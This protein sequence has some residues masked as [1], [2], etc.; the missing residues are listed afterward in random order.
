[1]RTL[2]WFRS[3][4]RVH[5]H[6]ALFH[7]C[8]DSDRGVVG[9][10][11]LSPGEWRAHDTAAV[12]IDFTLRT[13]RELSRDLQRL[14]VPL[15]IARSETPGEIPRTLLAIAKR[16]AC[17]GIAF[18][19]EYE[20]D[21]RAR[22]AEVARAFERARL[23]ACAYDDQLILEPGSVRTKADTWF[24][25]FTP[26]KNQWMNVLESREFA[27]PLAAPKKRGE[28]VCPPDEVPNAIEGF[29]SSVPSGLWPA[30][31]KHARK[32]L[33][34]F[35]EQRL[36][37][38]KSDRDAPAIDG[39]STLSPYLA[40][41]AVSPRQCL[42]AAM[43][44]NNAKASGGRPGPDHWISELVWREFYHHLLVAF[45]RLCKHRPFK[46]ATERI[47]WSRDEALFARWCDGNTGVPIVD[48]A[49]R[50]LVQTGWM[51]NRCRMIVAMYLT[52][53][54]WIDWRWGER[55]FMRHLVD[56]NLACNN[57]GW[58]WSASTGTDA[59]PY[60][61]IYNPVSQSVAHDPDGAYIKRFVPELRGLDGES[62]HDPG[63]LPP[64]A[65]AKLDYPEVAV[66]HAKARERVMREFRGIA[67]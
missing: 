36:D 54:Y 50:Q 61:R 14:G 64:L 26:F 18:N 35:I 65:R 28:L 59:A 29:E 57:G 10:Y 4:L 15:L 45:P 11:N 16:H 21:E 66:D 30:G 3:D 8:R 23:A 41:G 46:L 47:E 58:Q 40:I 51:H 2:V 13:L 5:D 67:N 49:M 52:K 39:T 24:T 27:T 31:E 7:A 25:V 1:M 53:D 22:D 32:R 44:S 56:G 34:T 12:R 42:H 17:D 60:F 37:R 38:Y 20:F 9:V 48:A 63:T 43:A 6:A 55:F 19:R 33:E 62:I